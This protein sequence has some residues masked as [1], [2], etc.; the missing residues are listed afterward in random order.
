[1]IRLGLARPAQ[2]VHRCGPAVPIAVAERREAIQD[3][4][5]ELQSRGSFRKEELD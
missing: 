2:P 4:T 3:E 1:M 5:T